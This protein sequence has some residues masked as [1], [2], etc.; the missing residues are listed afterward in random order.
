MS[1]AETIF[2]PRSRS[3]LGAKLIETS[4]RIAGSFAD[5]RQPPF[6][7]WL[8]R[9][10]L[11][12]M[13]AYLVWRL[14]RVGWTEIWAARPKSL[15]FYGLLLASYLTLPVADTLIYSRLWKIGFWRS[16]PAFLRKRIYNAAV[17]GYSGELFLMMWA[18]RHVPLADRTLAHMI[19]DTN[20]L[21]AL[22]STLISAGLTLYVL[23]HLPLAALQASHWQYWAAATVVIASFIPIAMICRRKFML[24]DAGTAAAVFGVHL[25]RFTVIQILQLG[26]W[27]LQLPGAPL[28]ILA[29]LLAVQLLIGRIPFLPNGDVLFVGVGIGLSGPL[30][31]PQAALTS[32][33]VTA[34]LF[35][36]V[37]HLAVYAA[38]SFGRA[39]ALRSCAS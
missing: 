4:R 24:L 29:A 1:N 34:S 5:R 3:P 13:L 28:N 27:T 19:K 38:T 35:Q 11:L 26:L 8:G 36:Q 17:V 22:V 20:I 21:S 32:L 25:A 2:Q 33:L 39:T 9:L 15:A 18:R 23:V 14:Q 37:A 12:G 6:A 31:L 10:F 16:L 7:K 30:A